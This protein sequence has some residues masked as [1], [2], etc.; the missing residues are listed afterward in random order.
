MEAAFKIAKYLDVKPI[1][2]YTA[3]QLFDKFIR[4][5]FWEIC[6][7]QLTNDM[8]NISF[9]EA[10]EIDS[11]KS[12]LYLILCF[13]LACKMDSTYDNFQISAVSIFR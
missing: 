13:Y 12:M 2:K 10:S 5:R 1:V 8:S 4:C 6:K 7:I 3:I 9:K 11:P